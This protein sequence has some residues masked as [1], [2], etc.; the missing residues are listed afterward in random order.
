[1]VTNYL[2]SG[3]AGLIIVVLVAGTIAATAGGLNSFSTVLT[4]DI[5][6]KRFR[7]VASDKEL[8]WVGQLATIAIA[9]FSIVWALTLGTFN[10]DILNLT[11]GIVSFWPRPW[12]SCS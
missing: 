8:H 7:P 6:V 9:G 12:P 4:L 2:P 1:M 5:Y 3:I 11:Q 10:K